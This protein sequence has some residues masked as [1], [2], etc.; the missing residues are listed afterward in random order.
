MVYNCIGSID[1]L[2]R[3]PTASFTTSLRHL[4]QQLTQQLHGTDDG[5]DGEQNSGTVTRLRMMQLTTHSV[6]VMIRL[7]LDGSQPN[8]PA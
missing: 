7:Q 5:D 8:L 6:D 2:R 3:Q 1:V 4:L